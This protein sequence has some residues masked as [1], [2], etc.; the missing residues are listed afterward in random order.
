VRGVGRMKRGQGERC[1]EVNADKGGGKWGVCGEGATR[2]GD[3]RKKPATERHIVLR[4]GRGGGRNE[5]RDHR[6]TNKNAE[7][8][9]KKNRIVARP[10]EN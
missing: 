3:E 9:L 4:F 2:K 6:F 10:L 7:T 5:G 1:R 8:S